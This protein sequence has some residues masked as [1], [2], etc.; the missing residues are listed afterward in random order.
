[1]RI[2]N[3]T[4]LLIVFIAGFFGV[5][6]KEPQLFVG[7]LETIYEKEF[8]NEEAMANA[9]ENTLVAPFAD[10]QA[11]AARYIPGTGDAIAKEAEDLSVP[12]RLSIH[13]SEWLSTAA[14]EI[15][16][17]D[18]YHYDEHL[19]KIAR[20]FNQHG[21]D[22]YKAFVQESGMLGTV[23]SR[24]MVMTASAEQVP[25]LL[26]EG[27]L[28]GRYRWLFDVPLTLTG[29]RAGL[30]SYAEAGAQD[31]FEVPG[32]IARIQVGRVSGNSE[33]GVVIESIAVRKSVE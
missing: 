14:A 13:L 16:S 6:V 33:D 4:F 19:A 22:Q 26:K 20:L 5:L 29:V 10:P 17:I 23:E 31:V 9:P 1:M 28:D 32:I 8:V 15:F 24:G 21:Y 18:P 2:S 7:A 27:A 25:I 11:G 3:S 30:N 12:H